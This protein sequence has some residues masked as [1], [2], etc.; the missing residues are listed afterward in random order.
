MRF[1]WSTQIIVDTTFKIFKTE[2]ARNYHFENLEE[3]E[4]MLA[5]YINWFN[6]IRIH[7]TLGYLSPKQYKQHNL[8]KTV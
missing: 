2:F 4:F 8:K 1:A 7:S 3:L 5:D 6:N